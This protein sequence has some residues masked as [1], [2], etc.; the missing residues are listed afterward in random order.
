LQKK[1]KKMKKSTIEKQ[2]KEK[3]AT[4]EFAPS[5]DSWD[6]LNAMLTVAEEP[7]RSFK[8]MYV[9]ASILGFL[10][11]NTLFFNQIQQ[12]IVLN[13][14]SKLSSKTK[15]IQEPVSIVAP[16]RNPN[17]T[18]VNNNEVTAK[19]EG[20]SIASDVSINKDS[21]IVQK[22]VLQEQQIPIITQGFAD[23]LEQ[24]G[25]NQKSEQDTGSQQSRYVN[26]E[27]LLAAVDPLAQKPNT[28]PLPITVVRVN[29]ND[30]LA[31]VDGELEL[32]F[33]EKALKVVNQKIK[34][35]AV[36]LSNR[37]SE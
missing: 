26:V 5:H 16:I 20:Q 18:I 8:W 10:L 2:F 37:N 30:L 4:R 31:Q 23:R 15:T 32:S 22:D 24:S 35:A 6:R 33:R 9:A 11:I 34:T 1:I 12:E 14:V 13:K 25:K 36:V 19:K 27:A 17:A 28:K 3:L 7:K 21:Q 29:S